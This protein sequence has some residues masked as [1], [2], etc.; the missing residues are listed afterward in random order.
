[1]KWKMKLLWLIVVMLVSMGIWILNFPFYGTSIDSLDFVEGDI[2]LSNYSFLKNG[3]VALTGQI[4]Y[5]P[6]RILYDD[7]FL[8]DFLDEGQL[9]QVDSFLDADQYGS[10][11]YGTYLMRI[12]PPRTQSVIALE[13]PDI[14]SAYK[15]WVNK[16][17]VAHLGRVDTRMSI[18]KPMTMIKRVIIPSDTEYLDIL[19]QVSNYNNHHIGFNDPIIIGTADQIMKRQINSVLREYLIITAAL[20]IGLYHIAIFA[21][22]EDEI[23]PL[24]FGLFSIA[25]ALFLSVFGEKSIYNV[26]PQ[27]SWTARL[28]LGYFLSCVTVLLLLRYV[29]LIGEKWKDTIFEKGIQITLLNAYVGVALTL[30]KT[31]QVPLINI[32]TSLILIIG[33]YAFTRLLVHVKNKEVGMRLATAGMFVALL[34]LMFD[35]SGIYNEEYSSYGLFIFLF[36]QALALGFRYSEA[37]KINVSLAGELRLNARILEERNSDIESARIRL[38]VLNAELDSKV[39]ERTEDISLLLDHSGQAFLSVDENSKIQPGY[40]KLANV[41]IGDRIRKMDFWSLVYEGHD[42]TIEMM[43]RSV[44]RAIHETSVLRRNSYLGLLPDTLNY[45]NHDLSVEYKWIKTDFKEQ[46]M[47]IMTDVTYEKALIEQID[48]ESRDNWSNLKIL[49]NI[50]EFWLLHDELEDFFTLEVFS[51]IDGISEFHQLKD[52]LAK[53]L[54]YFKGSFSIY[55]MDRVVEELHQLE[56]IL[57][58]N[59]HETKQ[60]LKSIFSESHAMYEMKLKLNRLAIIEGVDIYAYRDAILVSKSK[61]MEITKELD[62]HFGDPVKA[63]IE[64]INALSHIPFRKMFESYVD[65]VSFLGKDNGKKINPLQ[66]SGGDFLIDPSQYGEFSRAMVHI[67]RNIIDH[68][69]EKPDIRFERGKSIEGNIELR[70][71]REKLEQREWI[72]L[73]VADDGGGID[74]QRL[75]ERASKSLHFEQNV[76]DRMN[77]K[78]LDQ[79]IF[80]PEISTKKNGDIFSG[81][82]LGMTLVK[83]AVLELGGSIMVES[84]EEKGVNFI[85]EVPYRI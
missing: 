55:G 84:K 33:F 26:F 18:G 77:T 85:I 70:I 63:Y 27:I 81:R 79:L 38:E 12:K 32:Y 64:E 50:H 47:I 51:D 11:G 35:L 30:G 62:M 25:L 14:S 10:H 23:A 43:R 40:S 67:F 15:M 78:D 24:Y 83:E 17:L 16:S 5:I 74:R 48:N 80:A 65:Y 76:I 8:E 54:H 53:K 21:M 7:E 34:I 68:G 75:K 4:H 29:I 6:D 60:A 20:L 42:E 44:K 2:D 9:V 57:S 1:M 49:L 58:E 22:R 13:I 3:P 56:E 45:N 36:S 61:L 46:I 73:E 69:I 41:Y 66:I 52:F 19:I 31:V 37:F 59:K 39:I 71:S 82:G 72:R 28:Q